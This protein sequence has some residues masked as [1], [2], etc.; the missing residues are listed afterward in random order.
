MFIEKSTIVF[1]NYSIMKKRY[2]ILSGS[3]MFLELLVLS[4]NM[5]K[6][7]QEEMSGFGVKAQKIYFFSV[8]GFSI[9]LIITALYHTRAFVQLLTNFD[10]F[11]AF[12]DD[13]VYNEVM[14]KAQKHLALIVFFFCLAKMILF[15]YIRLEQGD[16]NGDIGLVSFTVSNYNLSSCDFRYVYQYFILHSLLFVISEQLKA[17]MR[18]IDKVTE[19]TWTDGG[20]TA[21]GDTM[22]PVTVTMERLDMLDKW[23]NAYKNINDSCNLWNRMFRTQVGC[24]IF[25]YSIILILKCGVM[26]RFHSRDSW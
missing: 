9:Y 11:Y 10:A 23:V 17:I 4:I 22:K 24:V 26:R 21:Q 6:Y 3:W 1:R 18:S 25:V 15:A 7:I 8:S 14:K 20:Y 12:F 5:Y 2:R 19:T 13:V 16:Y